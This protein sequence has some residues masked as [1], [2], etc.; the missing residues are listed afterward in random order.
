[1]TQYVKAAA[2][3]V[4]ATGLLW[5]GAASAQG[6]YEG[7]VV[8]MIV[9]HSASGGFAKYSQL[10]A[11]AL[12]EKL[13][14]SDVRIEHKSGAGGILGSNLVWHS[15]P[16]GLTIGFSSGTALMLAQMAGGEGV[17]FDATKFTYLGRPASD[18]RVIF[19]RTASELKTADD[20]KKIGRELKVPS[21][22]VDDD[23][24]ATAIIADAVGFKV[25]YITG[26]EGGAD[27]TLAVIKGDGD[28][29]LTSWTS[30][31]PVIKNGDVRP[32]LSI[33]QG[34]NGAYPDTPNALDIVT[35]PKK[36]EILQTLINI[37]ELHRTFFG[38]PGIDDKVATEM[39]AAVMQ[40]LKDPAVLE[41]AKQ[42]DLPIDPM[43]GAQQ[44]KVVG[45]IYKQSAAIP[46][47]LK[48]ATAS[49]K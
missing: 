2:A 6:Y 26:Y 39:R 5:S 18:D 9:P 47:V 30:A 14:A 11:P 25:K 20:L 10:F 21:Q 16:D 22:G 42:L 32:L 44:Q 8:T 31:V 13:K 35:D 45:E 1:M 49:I 43:D 3:A 17:Q 41:K 33:G 40:V 7:K 48:N 46:D 23:F 27:T 12:K 19:T 15:K 37:Q 4:L 34:R 29:R 24:Y 36:K 38:P 28:M